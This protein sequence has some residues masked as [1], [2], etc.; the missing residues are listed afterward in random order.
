MVHPMGY[1]RTGDIIIVIE[2]SIVIT[3]NVCDVP[4]V[5]V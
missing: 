3:P 5:I 2:Q 1:F 4:G